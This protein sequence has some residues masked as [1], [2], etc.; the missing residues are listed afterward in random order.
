MILKEYKP[1]WLPNVV[2]DKTLLC[3]VRSNDVKNA[4]AEYYLMEPIWLVY[5]PVTSCVNDVYYKQ[6]V[7]MFYADTNRR[8]W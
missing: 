8:P 6:Y 5:T 4:P 3:C 7:A 2:L 1:A